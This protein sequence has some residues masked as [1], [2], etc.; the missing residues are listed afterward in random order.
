MG[1]AVILL[2]SRPPAQLAVLS[3]VLNGVLLPFVLVFMLILVNKESLMGERKNGLF[4]NIV[5]WTLT[6]AATVLTAVML[7]GTL[8]G[9]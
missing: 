7:V 3:Q 8:K 4:Y 6:I 5:A 1:A 9:N 2:S